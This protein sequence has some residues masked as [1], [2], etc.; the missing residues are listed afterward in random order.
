M[1]TLTQKQQEK[2]TNWPAFIANFEGYEIKT[3]K[4]MGVARWYYITP[5]GSLE[6]WHDCI[7]SSDSIENING[8]LYGAVQVKCGII[9]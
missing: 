9:K 8:W 7:Y 2:L 6:P 3:Y 5:A 4:A 1:N